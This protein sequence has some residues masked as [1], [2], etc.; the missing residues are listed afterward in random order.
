MDSIVYI[1]DTKVLEIPIKESNEPLVD[2]REYNV[3]E[4][5]SPPE[6]N[7]TTHY[8][9]KVR[10]TVYDKLCRVQ[11]LLPNRWRLRLYEGFRSIRV[12][13]ILFEEE[14]QRVLARHPYES[15]RFLFY[16]ATKLVSP[17]INF[18][19]S[20]NIPAHNTGG[21]VDIEIIMDDGQLLD[22]GMA[23]KDWCE[24]D[25]RICATHCDLIS[26]TAQ[27][28]RRILLENMQ[29]QGF[30]NYPTEWW[31]FSYGDRYWAYH[32]PIKLAI[33]GSADFLVDDLNVP[34]L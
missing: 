21:A 24:A 20:K 5:G 23:A 8:Y 13:Q 34:D 17:V 29:V 18:D 22:M 28:N 30:I 7:L 12:Q 27:K 16:E 9:T 25:P 31:H 10:K 2:L 32:Q 14:Y 6:N 15:H 33:Y 4:Y 11:T 19:G 1:T 3:L 26:E